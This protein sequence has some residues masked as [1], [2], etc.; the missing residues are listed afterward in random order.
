MYGWGR[1]IFQNR[2]KKIKIHLTC[3]LRVYLGKL[4]H[5]R[6]VRT[7][8]HCL[9]SV[10]SVFTQEFSLVVC[11]RVRPENEPKKYWSSVP[12]FLGLSERPKEKFALVG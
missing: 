5:S 7:F 6:S 11:F 4:M 12:I 3:Q 9:Q 8:H 2:S 1:K 10:L